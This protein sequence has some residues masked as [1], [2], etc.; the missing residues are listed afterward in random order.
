MALCLKE[1]DDLHHRKEIG[2]RSNLRSNV[3]PFA[4]KNIPTAAR[5]FS[6]IRR[7]FSSSCLWIVCALVAGGTTDAFAKKRIV[8]VVPDGGTAGTLVPVGEDERVTMVRVIGDIALIKVEAE[9]PEPQLTFET[10]NGTV[11]DFPPPD[12]DNAE[13]SF[14]ILPDGRVKVSTRFTYN[15]GKASTATFLPPG[16]ELAGDLPQP[17]G[18]GVGFP[19]GFHLIP[20]EEFR[21]LDALGIPDTEDHQTFE[22]PSGNL[23]Y[24][25][26]ATGDE[27]VNYEADA[28]EIPTVSEWGLI[29]ITLLVL[30]AG[31]IVL[32]RRSR[33]SVVS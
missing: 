25:T 6:R 9:D 2:M 8:V 29:V 28:A 16:T 22:V 4:D 1:Y 24:N 23:I 3:E 7:G 21:C 15:G 5:L 31:M 33:T 17:P 18:L 19:D 30:T 12:L 26:P 32:K 14:E 10:P 11:H 27:V 13:S 20:E